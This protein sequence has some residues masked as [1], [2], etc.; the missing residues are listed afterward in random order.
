MEKTSITPPKT[1]QDPAAMNKHASKP[2]KAS[3]TPKDKAKSR[4]T[5]Y[6]S[7]TAALMVAVLALT[8]QISLLVGPVPFTLQTAALIGVV[9]LLPR[10]TALLSVL[11][12]LLLGAVGL[13]I[14][15]TGRAGLGLL[16][17]ASGGFL[18][19]FIPGA[20]LGTLILGTQRR[21]AL[22]RAYLAATSA[23]ICS[24]AWGTIHY[25]FVMGVTLYQAFLV[26]S[27]PFIVVDIV[28]I[29]FFTPLFWK[30][31]RMLPQAHQAQRL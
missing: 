12:Y 23:I 29:I 30:I 18:F 20:L 14:F 19:G 15:S 8:A 4:L 16:A 31:R 5:V 7:T 17:G 27:L 1:N 26:A 28:K 9:L 11:V 3:P 10:R 24:F 21:P 6:E 2:G 25:S 22:W 13:P